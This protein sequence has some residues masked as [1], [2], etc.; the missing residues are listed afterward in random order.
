MFKV[1]VLEANVGSVQV[2]LRMPMPNSSRSGSEVMSVIGRRIAERVAAIKVAPADEIGPICEMVTTFLDQMLARIS[3]TEASGLL[4]R[5]VDRLNVLLGDK[6]LES[7]NPAQRTA[8]QDHITQV[9]ARMQSIEL[10]RK[11]SAVTLAATS[12]GKVGFMSRLGD[13]GAVM[14]TRSARRAGASRDKEAI[15]PHQPENAPQR[16]P[17]CPTFAANSV[18]L[19]LHALAYNLGNFMR[20]LAMRQTAEPCS[21]S[22]LREKLI[23]IAAKVVSHGPYVTFQMAEVAVLRQM[24]AD[25]LSLIARLRGPPVRV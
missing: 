4:Y 17:A 15:L 6:L 3:R 1:L 12:T 10:S 11:G 14:V 2:I 19:Q 13:D 22:S 7:V 24:F 25:I 18:R 21:L 8:F 23:K 5:V 20:T 9:F 16:S